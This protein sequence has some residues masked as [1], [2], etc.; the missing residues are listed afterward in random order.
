MANKMVKL[1][2]GAAKAAPSPAIGQALGP[3]G[4]NMMD[5][6]KAFNEKTK[7]IADGTPLPVN[8]TAFPNRTFDFTYATPSTAWFLKKC[9]G[10]DK[11]SPKPGRDTLG[12]VHVKQIYEIAKIK[13]TDAALLDVPLADICKSILGTAKVRGRRR[14]TSAV[15]SD[16][17][18]RCGALCCRTSLTHSHAHTLALA[19]ALSLAPAPRAQH[20]LLAPTTA[21]PRHRCVELP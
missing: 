17:D 9:V 4:L 21:V 10:A 2:V 6:C 18:T 3:L 13:Q 14:R 20:R 12:E 11:G 1:I 8:L 16:R 5:F 15:C 19:R 7:H